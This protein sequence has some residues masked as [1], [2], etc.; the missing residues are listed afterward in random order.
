MCQLQLDENYERRLRR[1]IKR[2][3]QFTEPF[4]DNEFDKKRLAASLVETNT[5]LA[6]LE[7]YKAILPSWPL[8]PAS[9]QQ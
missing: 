8:R 1:A 7:A 3:A 9:C 4:A 5:C 2:K 6:K